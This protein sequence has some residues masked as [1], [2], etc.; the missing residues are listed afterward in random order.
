MK[1]NG[2]RATPIK[3]CSRIGKELSRSN[4]YSLYSLFPRKTG[5]EGEGFLKD[6][7]EA[8]WLKTASFF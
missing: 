8:A 2:N 1:V 4:L 3:C 5:A 6:K 7:K